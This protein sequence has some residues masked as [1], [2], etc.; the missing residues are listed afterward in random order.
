VSVTWLA[1]EWT[2]APPG[3]VAGTTLRRGGFS[4]G[5]YASLNLGAHVGDDA[6]AV[7]RNRGLVRETCG[8]P[9]EPAWLSQVHGSRVVAA[10]PGSG[11]P[12]ADGAVTDRAG[13]VCA[14]LTADCLPVVLAARD[15]GRVAVAHAGWRGLSEGILEAT[16]AAMNVQSG[17][18][19]AWLGPAIS[20]RAFEVGGEVRDRFIG[21]D[22]A[23]AE[24]F[25]A[26]ERG[27]WQADLYRLARL[28]LERCGVGAIGGGG[29]CTF[30]EADDFFS[31][32]RDGQCGRMATFVFRRHESA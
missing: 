16:V 2:S 10:E 17:N 28:R 1:A 32:R 12:E 29:R 25:E 13:V 22:A 31:Y 7:A 20:Q 3:V 21:D 8:L 5:A 6:K 30:T 19:L 27:R 18:L 11:P 4:S 24:F 15:G 26:N 14:V 23:A 9:A